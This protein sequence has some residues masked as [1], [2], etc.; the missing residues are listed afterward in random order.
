MESIA[1]ELVARMRSKDLS[2]RE[3][4]TAHLARIERVNPRVNAVAAARRNWFISSLRCWFISSLCCRVIGHSD[5]DVVP[6]P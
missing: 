3:V 5:V 6:Q 1:V 4:M 2:A